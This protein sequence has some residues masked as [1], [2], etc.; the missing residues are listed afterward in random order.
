MPETQPLKWV[1]TA[2]FTSEGGVAYLRA[3][4]SVT[5][6]LA[7]AGRFATKADA[8]ALRKL[9]L[10]MEAILADPYLIEVAELPD[11]IDALSARERI[12]AAGPTIRVRRPDPRIHTH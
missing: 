4:K 11:G 7:E 2:N 5:R 9:A 12:R 3:D 6:V 10:G 1:V 8:E